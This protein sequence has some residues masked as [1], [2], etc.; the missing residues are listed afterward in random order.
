MANIIA[1]TI[2]L[3][4][5]T[6]PQDITL[7]EVARESGHGH[8]LIVEWFGGKSQLFAAV[9]NETLKKLTSSGDL[10]YADVPLRKDIRI[11][12][13]LFNYSQMH[14][15]AF[16]K[17]VRSPLAINTLIDRIQQISDVS[18]DQ[19]RKAASRLALQT[20]GIA[21]FREYFDLTDDEI[22]EMMQD[23]IG[24]TT[25]ITLPDNPARQ[26]RSDD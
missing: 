5:N 26:R 7:R 3:L 12:F 10:F 13:Q 4:E 6:P 20:L 14:N 11:V 24:M 16:V 25:G 18:P 15:P 22:V 21:L 8:R 2:R 9:V 23:E 19:A 17:E 1:A